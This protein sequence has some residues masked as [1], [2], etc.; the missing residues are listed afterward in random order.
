MLELKK[1]LNEI[2]G[3]KGISKIQPLKGLSHGNKYY[4]KSNKGQEMILVIGDASAQ[5]R[6]KDEMRWINYLEVCG[7]PTNR[8]LNFGTYDSG[9]KFY[10]ILSWL[11]GIDAQQ[12]IRNQSYVVCNQLGKKAGELLRKIH[13]LPLNLDMPYYITL[14]EEI[15]AC[16]AECSN[17]DLLLNK[18]PAMEV[19]IRFLDDNKGY[20]TTKSTPKLLHGDYHSSNVIFSKGNA[21]VIDWF[22]G[23]IGDP[24]EDFVRNVISSESSKYYASSLIDSYY[25]D[26]VPEE[27]WGSLAIYTAIHEL[28][29]TKYDFSTVSHN[30]ISF[31]EHQHKLVLQE[32]GGMKTIVPSYYAKR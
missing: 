7:I 9:Q 12:I 31:V 28:R 25:N 11:P 16:I 10:M 2:P 29:I 3:L 5:Y 26:N 24:I 19:F 14:S 13:S 17:D 18:Y 1:K 20:W 4:V 22:Y 23:T 6:M 32:Y 30:G 27:F 8:L 15:D 21:S